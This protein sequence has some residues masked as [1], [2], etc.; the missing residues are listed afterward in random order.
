LLLDVK[1]RSRIL[2][3]GIVLKTSLVG[4]CGYS[5]KSDAI[6]A[7]AMVSFGGTNSSVA[8]YSFSA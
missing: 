5:T 8:Q 3:S 1:S 6:D 4:F 2:S 7:I